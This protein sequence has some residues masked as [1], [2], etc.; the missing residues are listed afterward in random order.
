MVLHMS[1]A[2][3]DVLRN[4]FGVTGILMNDGRRCGSRGKIL[5]ANG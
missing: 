4:Q 2:R 3:Q 1:C 5:V